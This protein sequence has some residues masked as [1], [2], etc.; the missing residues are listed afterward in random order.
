MKLLS[1]IA[2]AALFIIPIAANDAAAQKKTGKADLVILHGK[3]YTLNSKQPW[4]KAFSASAAS[5]SASCLGW[6][7][8]TPAATALAG[9]GGTG[10]GVG[11]GEGTCAGA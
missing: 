4:P 6:E 9:G 10:A 5:D 8:V 1:R 3:I 2:T 11:A 7:S